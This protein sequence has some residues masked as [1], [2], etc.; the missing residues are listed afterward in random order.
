MKALEE[1]AKV[2]VQCNYDMH[3]STMSAVLSVIP[4]NSLRSYL[5]IIPGR[6]ILMYLVN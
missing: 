6:I 3:E 2:G 1:M 4:N 5:G